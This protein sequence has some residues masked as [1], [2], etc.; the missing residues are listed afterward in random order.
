MSI[1]ISNNFVE[2]NYNDSINIEGGT[3]WGKVSGGATVVAG[4]ATV[5]GGG[6]LLATPEPTL[7]TK[8]AGYGAVTTGTTMIGTGLAAIANN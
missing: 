8:F 1:A 4:A 3:F 7:T 2:L 5:V 6:A